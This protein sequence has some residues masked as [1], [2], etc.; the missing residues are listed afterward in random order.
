MRRIFRQTALD[1][2]S[3]PE[4]LDRLMRVTG[5]RAWIAL[6]GLCLVIFVALMWGIFGRVPTTVTGNG[7]LISSAGLFDIEVLGTG[8]LSELNVREGERVEVGQVIARLSQP[9]L[10][11]EIDQASDRVMFLR[12]EL[13]RTAQFT[14]ENVELE[15]ESLDR[16]RERIDA[17]TEVVEQRI[18]YL[19]GRVT[20][21]EEALSL[22]LLTQEAVH[23]TIQE[24]EAARGELA[25]LGLGLR[26]NQLRRQLISNESEQNLIRLEEEIREADRQVE[27]LQLQHDQTALV[28]SPYSG[29]IQELRGDPGQLVA[30]G[31]SVASL[32]RA[33]AELHAVVFVPSQGKR[34][35]VGMRAQIAPVTVKREEHGYMLGEVSFVS[36][37]PATPEGMM[38]ILRNATLVQELSAA[39]VPFMVEVALQRDDATTSGFQWSS[40][41]GPPLSVDSGTLCEVR[42]IVQEQRP[43][44]LVIP[45]FRRALGL[46]A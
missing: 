14:S 15:T 18:S 30:A 35:L 41:A 4:Q 1:R 9:R 29:V 23:N 2:L 19:E 39:G 20:A 16:E 43:I 38:R 31:T 5:P 7:I 33:D 34:A 13:E 8:V 37:Q 45:L 26:D 27:L 42:V 46:A 36:A 22:G 11:Q 24:M 17:R 44:T 40:P 21:E 12:Q 32:E 28:V 25:T 10:Q 6:G 3:S